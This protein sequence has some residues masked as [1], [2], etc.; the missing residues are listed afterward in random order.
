MQK[1]FIQRK[2][3]LL[4]ILFAIV[5]SASPTSQLFG[6]L[7]KADLPRL[8]LTGTNNGYLDNLYSDGRIWLGYSDV[9]ERE[10]IVPVYI[11][12]LWAEIGRAHV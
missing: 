12:N 6:Q 2:N 11:Q 1:W 3:V 8:S 10:V 5:M 9:K 7:Q 4:A